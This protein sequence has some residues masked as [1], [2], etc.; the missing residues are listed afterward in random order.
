M[1]EIR[2][3]ILLEATLNRVGIHGEPLVIGNVI[4]LFEQLG[5]L[6]GIR[7]LTLTTSGTQ[8]GRYARALK[9]AG[10]TRINM[11]LD[12]LRPESSGPSAATAS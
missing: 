3:G 7:D 6:P 4:W 12:S 1:V 11:S 10:V 5:A 8:L 2:D 9:D